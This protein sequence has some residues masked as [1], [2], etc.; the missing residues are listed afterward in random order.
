M[1][2][3]DK[4]KER[5][6]EYGIVRAVLLGELDR[7]M[8]SE[9][10]DVHRAFVHE[11]AR[12]LSSTASGFSLTDGKNEWGIDFCRAD[13]PVFTIA[14]CKCPEYPFFQSEGKPKP[15]DRDAFED[16]LTG[17]NFVCDED[18][19]YPQATLVLKQF[20][21]AYHESRRQWPKETRLQAALAVFG[22]LTPQAGNYFRNQRNTL[23]AKGVEL[24]LWNWEKF[25]DL[26]TTPQID[27]E[28]MKL[29]FTIDDPSKEILRRQAPICVVR[30]IDLVNAWNE[31]QWNLVDWNVR[32]E[33]R[34][35][36]TNKRIQ[37]TLLSPSG[38]RRFQ[39]YNNGLLVVCKHVNYANRPG[40]KLEITLRQPQV[41]NGCQT[42]L[43]LVRAYW[44][45]S[46]TDKIDFQESV[47]VTLKIIQ[48]QAPDYVERII[49]ST[50]D[51]NPM[52][53]RSLK[54]NTPEQK[55]LQETFG[56]F[57]IPYF[58]ERKDGQFDGLLHFGQKTPS[59]RPRDYQIAVGK[60]KYRVLDNEQIALE[61][62]AFIGHSDE[63]LRGGLRLFESDDLYRKAFLAHPKAQ[64]WDAVRKS[65]GNSPPVQSDEM[66][67]EGS[68]SPAQYLVAHIIGNLVGQRRVSFQKNRAAAIER[69]SRKGVIKVD[70]V[71]KPVDDAIVV[72]SRLNRDEKYLLGTVINNMQDVIIELYAMVLS[73]R[74]GPLGDTFCTGLLKYPPIRPHVEDPNTLVDNNAK[75]LDSKHILNLIYEFIRFSLEQFVIKYGE[76][77]RAQPRSKS[78]LAQR[79][80]VNMIRDFLLQANEEKTPNWVDDWCP[81][82]SPFIE[83]LPDLP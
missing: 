34:S 73:I 57:F 63:T 79:N 32:A 21:N 3:S 18:N 77:I 37:N 2:G 45:L 83:Q 9:D 75:R 23:E 52:S 41:V 31:Y 64:F 20:K 62:L 65:P 53:A 13:A 39:D 25:S 35:S 56:R 4:K 38:R 74:Y 72:E 17:I 14:Q 33:I 11:T 28:N 46:E 81:G 15:Y 68:P 27:I 69:L 67:E 78:Y 55:R 43:S 61:W 42:L 60:K 47:R 54:S 6:S 10:C 19:P 8:A 48:N 24:L 70:A 80:T 76:V 82:K 7:I 51:Q 29:T 5:K 1:P 66:F 44:D 30:G 49:Q 40:N 12:V 58:Y 16:L 50:N 71:G 59:F 36:P 22:E 26:L